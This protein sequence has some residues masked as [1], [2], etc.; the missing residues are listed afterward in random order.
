MTELL[1]VAA[2][3]GTALTGVNT[4]LIWR[5]HESHGARV[6]R[7]VAA[8]LHKDGETQAAQV[9]SPPEKPVQPTTP[10]HEA[11]RQVGLS[12]R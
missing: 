4:F 5:M 8:I 1:Q 6:D 12:P 10:R 3:A 9:V 11:P 2:A 7:L